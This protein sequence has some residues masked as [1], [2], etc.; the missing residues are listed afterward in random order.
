MTKLV[1]RILPVLLSIGVVAAC[2]PASVSDSSALTRVQDINL[3]PLPNNDWQLSDGSIQLSFC[4]NRLNDALLATAEDLNRWRLVQE[5]SALPKQRQRGLAE[6]AA[7]YS[8]HGVL[9]WQEWG[10][11]SSQSYR[12]VSARKSES[13]S[14]IDAL[15]RLGRDPR[16]CYSAIDSATGGT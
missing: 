15:A 9:L 3:Q 1:R 13:P 16:I 12:I 11:V 8:E 5:P 7:L 10:T 4:R 2:T 6:L 14:L